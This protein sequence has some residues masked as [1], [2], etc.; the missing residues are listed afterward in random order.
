MFEL[1]VFFGVMGL[2]ALWMVW[3]LLR[4]GNRRTETAE[5]L[6]IEQARREQAASDRSSYNA[7]A[8]LNSP[9]H[10]HEYRP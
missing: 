3:S 1:G 8:M 10:G 7:T 6:L 4:R 5:G 2:A 9:T